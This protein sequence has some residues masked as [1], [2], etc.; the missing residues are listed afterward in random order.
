MYRGFFSLPKVRVD[1][2]KNFECFTENDITD[3]LPLQIKVINESDL[4]IIKIFFI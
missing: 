1:F 4:V 3:T 2:D